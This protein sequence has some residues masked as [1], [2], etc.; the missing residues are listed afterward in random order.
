MGIYSATTEAEEALAAATAESAWS[1]MGA[2]TVKAV[3]VEFGVSFDGVTAA[4]EPVVVELYQ[5]TAAG[6]GTGAAEAKWDRAAP[7]AQCTVLHSLTA[8]PTKGDRLAMWV[9]HP[10]GGLLVVQ[11]PLGREP[12][13]SDGSASQGLALTLTAPAVV[14][15]SS[16]LIWQE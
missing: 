14:N 15:A 16:Y 8:E 12:V 2:T 9:V 3:L 4:A 1:I 6:T 7:T 5:I 10:Q 11:Y 13:I